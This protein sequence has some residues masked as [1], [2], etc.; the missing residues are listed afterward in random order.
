V[1]LQANLD[2]LRSRFEREGHSGKIRIMQLIAGGAL[3][4]CCLFLGEQFSVKT[5]VPYM[6]SNPMRHD[7]P[8]I[9]Q[10]MSLDA[11][12]LDVV[13]FMK[14]NG[15]KGRMLTSWTAGAFLLFSDPEIKVFMDARDQSFYS[16]EIIELYFSIMKSGRGDI[17]RTLE[18]LDRYQVAYAVLATNVGDFDLA[19]L[20][21]ETRK[22][23]CIY[24]DDEFLL[25]ARSDSEKLHPTSLSPSLN[26]L[27]YR[28]DDT[29]L[30]SEAVRFQF[31]T[32]KV[33]PELLT[34]LQDYCRREPYPDLYSLITLA[35]SGESRCL[36]PEA[37]SFLMTEAQ[38]L[39]KMDYMIAAGAT[40]IVK[41]LII[42]AGILESDELRCRG[43]ANAQTYSRLRMGA[44]KIYTELEAKYRGY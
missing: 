8:L 32:G 23:A 22:W 6:P 39:A 18:A 28:S 37:R 3:T 12:A 43:G 21:M 40:S 19:T 2:G 27:K 1:F 25:L 10:L 20:L 36:D 35:L 17:P 5:V 13:R 38:R 16:D 11:Y 29:R 34:R 30:V 41:S 4:A 31:M 33:P 26:A 44:A 24:K 42:V 9:K 7:R 15:I 14:D